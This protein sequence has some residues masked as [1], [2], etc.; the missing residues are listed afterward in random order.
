[1]AQYL[2]QDTTLTGIADAIRGKTGGSDPI[3]V[4]DM[5]TQI[6]GI[7]TGGGG[8]VVFAYTA[9]VSSSG[10]KNSGRYTATI[11]IPQDATDFYMCHEGATVSAYNSSYAITQ[12]W[13]VPGAVVNPSNL[14]WTNR[15]DGYKSAI[16]IDETF[17]L[18]SG[19]SLFSPSA[20]GELKYMFIMPNVTIENNILYANAECKGL[21]A[22]QSATPTTRMTSLYL[23]GVDLRGSQVKEIKRYSFFKVTELK[24]VWF[25]EQTTNIGLQAFKDCTG[26][27]EIHFTS[28]T[29]P[30]VESGAFTGVPTT[31][32]IYVPAGTLSAYQGKSNY[33]SKTTYTYIEE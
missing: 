11:I 3:L 30:T 21:F 32:K 15:T 9:K 26:L 13:N 5:A 28:T 22:Y 1:M 14:V 25:S 20:A 17:N 19:T 18:P 8:G 33:P 2:I 23:E 16:Y 10:D 6:E 4:S 27:E 24:K 7:T 29:P 31:C 12:S